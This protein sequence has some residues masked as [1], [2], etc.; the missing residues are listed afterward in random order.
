VNP[1]HELFASA[2]EL[3]YAR[4]GHQGQTILL[5]KQQSGK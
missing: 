4:A 5:A 2:A 1:G 3:E